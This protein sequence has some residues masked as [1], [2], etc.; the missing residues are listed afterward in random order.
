MDIISNP[1]CEDK[2]KKSA[3]WVLC[4]ALKKFYDI[5]NRLPVN[6]TI[7]DMTSTPEWYIALQ[8]VY[9]NK[10]LAD[11]ELIKGHITTILTERGIDH[12]FLAENDELIVRFCK[13]ANS[14]QVTCL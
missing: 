10:C 12:S 7:P 9:R 1:L 8:H 6:G 5:E 14:L 4:G 2:D 13:N 3:F 11:I